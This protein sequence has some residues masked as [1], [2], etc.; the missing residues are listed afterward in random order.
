[1]THRIA[2]VISYV[3][4]PLLMSTYL[5][6][7]LLL[8]SPYSIMPI[9][10]SAT[11]GIVLIS[12]IGITTFIIPVLS[13]YVLKLSGSISSITL[14]RRE[15]RLTPMIYTSIMYGVTA[16]MF[17]TKL[18][19]GNMLALY[20]GIS[21][22]LILVTGVI[23]VFWKISL[24][25]MGIGGFIGFLLGLNQHVRLAHFEFLLP[26]LFLVAAFILSARL[27]LNAHSPVQVY[28]G[29]VLGI[30]ISFVSLIIYLN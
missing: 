1:M 2:V 15:E 22:L 30:C 18:E 4:H 21:T 29:F 5:F 3:L 23:T 8:I 12:L 24:H 16:Y 25:G 11:S 6:A 9:G 27:K 26:L 17:S 20:L 28:V 14:E 19:L 7:T 13:L 10:F